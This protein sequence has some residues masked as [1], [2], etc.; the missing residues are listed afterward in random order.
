MTLRP[1][2]P[3]RRTPVAWIVV[4]IWVV[5]HV[6]ALWFS[7]GTRYAPGPWWTWGSPDPA[8]LLRMGA[9][10]EEHVQ[11]GEWQRLVTYAFLHSFAL[12]LLLHAWVWLSIARFLEGVIG[13]AR[14]VV[15]LAASVLAG[16]AT[17]LYLYEGVEVGAITAVFGAVGALGVWAFV[18]PHP[19][20]RGARGTAVFFVL[21]SAALFFVPGVAHEGQV[22]GLLAGGVA[23]AALGPHRSEGRPGLLVR[24][25]AGLLVLLALFAA[26]GQARAP[27][28]TSASDDFL[29]E[30]ARVERLAE[31]LYERPRLARDVDRADLGRRLGALAAEPWIEDW[32]GEDAL[33][34][35]LDLW[36]QVAEANVPDPSAFETARAD[37][38]AAWLPWRRRLELAA[39]RP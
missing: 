27:V 18:S 37:A 6:L 36:R 21:F 39:G 17:H 25:L 22:A 26:A 1:P 32:E 29:R 20:A 15:I 24:L 38:R 11:L 16:A 12:H 31:R 7:G 5:S 34:T 9:L 13:S 10:S 19:A 35:W 4:L 33:R 3:D 14:V 8:V 30:L 23:M 2:E 28:P